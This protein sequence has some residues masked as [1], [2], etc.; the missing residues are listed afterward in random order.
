MR[1]NYGYDSYRGRSKTRSILMGIIILLL[2]VLI[3][4]VAAFFLLQDR[5]YYGD[6]GK[7]HIDLP[8]FLVRDNDPEPSQAP[9]VQTPNLVIVTPEPTPEPSQEPVFSPV[10]LPRSALTDGS[11]PETVAQAGGSAALF[12]MKDDEGTLGYVSQLPQAISAGASAAQPGLNEAIASL[13][14]TEGLYTVARVACFRDNLVPKMNNTLALRSPI[15]NWRD[16]EVVRWLSPAVAEARSYV[17]GVCRELA[18]LGF[19]EI[20]LDYAGF[21]TSADGSLSNLVVGERYDPETLSQEVERFYQEVTAALTDYPQVKVSVSASNQ[22]FSG[23]G[24]ESGQTLEL[25]KTYAHR[26]YVP[27]PADSAAAKAYEKTQAELGEDLPLPVYTTPA[28]DRE[29]PATSFPPVGGG[30][31]LHPTDE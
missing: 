2:I 6:D 9:V 23:T 10:A 31:I 5:V 28:Y 17:T 18:E 30:Q 27:G 1:S 12:D 25:L 20:W 21:P 8:S 19:D 3:L 14:D 16:Q 4:A 11:A 29:P 24:D 15:G 13:N 22:L 7:A 26:I